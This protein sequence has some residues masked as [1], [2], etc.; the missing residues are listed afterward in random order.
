MVAISPEFLSQKQK[1]SLLF[2]QRKRDPKSHDRPQR[3][4]LAYS[5]TGISVVKKIKLTVVTRAVERFAFSESEGA[6]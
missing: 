5:E 2:R 1:F 3:E 4:R 6:E